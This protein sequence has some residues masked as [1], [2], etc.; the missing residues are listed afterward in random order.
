MDYLLKTDENYPFNQLKLHAPQPIQGGTYLAKISRSGNPV[1]FQTPKCNT[2]RGIHKTEKKI[3]CDLLF[4]TDNVEFIEWLN[5]IEE[6][7]QKLIYEKKDLWFVEGEVSMEDIEYNWIDTVKNYKKSHLL[8]T[9][10]P[11]INKQTYNTIQVYDDNQNLLSIDDIKENS[12]L[13]SIIEL[14]AL[15]FSSSSFH[16]E[17]V[18]RQAM[19]IKEKPVFNKCL[20]TLDSNK[21]LEK[22]GK[23]EEPI[24]EEE[25][26]VDTEEVLNSE[27]PIKEKETQVIKV[28]TQVETQVDN[29]VDTIENVTDKEEEEEEGDEGDEV[30]SEEESEEE[31]EEEEEENNEEEKA[32]KVKLLITKKENDNSEE[33][34]INNNKIEKEANTLEKNDNILKLN[35]YKLEVPKDSETM[36]LKTPNEVYLEVYKKARQKAK[37]AREEAI[38]AFLTLKKIKK[39]YLLD[40]I[41]LSEDESDEEMEL[42]FSEK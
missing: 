13:I 42:L 20:I 19:I 26:T 8:R 21:T 22:V 37:Q 16:L 39:Q 24:K 30:T 34:V 36:N 12:S 41:E 28:E 27:E 29:Q 5:T 6:H 3:Y 14:S 15:K 25:T 2:K 40:E 23:E 31:D 18:L 10:I 38:K 33:V 7:I 11:K 35:E 17:F 32:E 1:L 9:F 4:D